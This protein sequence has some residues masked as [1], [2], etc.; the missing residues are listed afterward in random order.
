MTGGWWQYVKSLWPFGRSRGRQEA[1]AAFIDSQ[2]RFI[3]AQLDLEAARRL[4]AE[5]GAAE[6]VVRAHNTANRYND[7]LQEVMGRG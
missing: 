7:W 6:Q 4:S 1:R 5:A 2:R 3:V